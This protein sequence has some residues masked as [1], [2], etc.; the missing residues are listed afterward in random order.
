MGVILVIVAIVTGVG[1]SIALSAGA[2][3]LVCRAMGSVKPSGSA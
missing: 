3:E 2:I 1:L